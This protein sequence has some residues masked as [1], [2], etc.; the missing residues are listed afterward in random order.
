MANNVAAPVHS[1]SSPIYDSASPRYSTASP[2][3]FASW[4]DHIAPSQR[5]PPP[6]AKAK[7]ESFRRKAKATHPKK[8]APVPLLRLPDELLLHVFELVCEEHQ[9]SRL[10]DARPPMHYLRI[11]KRINALILPRWYRKLVVPSYGSRSDLFMTGLLRHQKVHSLVQDIDFDVTPDAMHLHMLVVSQL[12]A[13]R[14][15][16]VSFEELYEEEEEEIPDSFQNLLADLPLLRRLTFRSA[17]PFEDG[18]AYFLLSERAPTIE[19]IECFGESLLTDILGALQLRSLKLRSVPDVVV[20]PWLDLER[21]E[22]TSHHFNKVTYE[23]LLKSVKQET[24]RGEVPLKLRHLVCDL[25]YQDPATTKQISLDAFYDH[26]LWT[27]RRSPLVALE[28]TLKEPFSTVFKGYDVPSVRSL[29]VT[30]TAGLHEKD[31][32]A[33][34]GSF[35]GLFSNLSH[36]T[37][38]KIRFSTLKNATLQ[39]C[40]DAGP[41]KRA[42]QYPHLT[43]LLVSLQESQV[44]DFRI[45]E[46]KQQLRWTRREAEGPFQ[47]EK[48]SGA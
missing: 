10:F 21:L 16:S 44:V 37:L 25:S 19:H 23:K 18:F 38:A 30:T 39:A 34:L 26:F 6:D 31:C 5:E 35:L 47:V 12:H 45:D 15:L 8:S 7:R 20:I 11:C 13:L 32:L 1:P 9:H 22:L 28:I 24:Q 40:L 41:A 42:V 17:P 36:L 43:A 3:L 14:S 48:W 4:N 29:T 46:K 27:L 2:D 33:V